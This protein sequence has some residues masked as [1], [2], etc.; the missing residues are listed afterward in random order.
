[1]K[2]NKVSRFLEKLDIKYIFSCF[3]VSFFMSMLSF[4]GTFYLRETI[5]LFSMI[6][7]ISSFWF[8]YVRFKSDQKKNALYESIFIDRDFRTTLAKFDDKELQEP[9]IELVKFFYLN[10]DFIN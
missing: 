9:M 6:F 7:S 1:M 4:F 3:I 10:L 8:I 2:K 5:F